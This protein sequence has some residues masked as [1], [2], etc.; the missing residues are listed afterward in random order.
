MWAEP[1]ELKWFIYEVTEISG[2]GKGFA[3]RVYIQKNF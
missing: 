1:L 3:I 2:V